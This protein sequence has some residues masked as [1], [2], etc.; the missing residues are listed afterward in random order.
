MLLEC[1]RA[2]AWRHGAG[3]CVRVRARAGAALNIYIHIHT[4]YRPPR[5]PPRWHWVGV[6]SPPLLMLMQFAPGELYGCEPAAR[7]HAS[8]PQLPE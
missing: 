1:W 5:P 7:V 3:R 8:K 6:V 2:L 4:T